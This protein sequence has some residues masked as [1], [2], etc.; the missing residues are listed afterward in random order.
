MRDGNP[1]FQ[2]EDSTNPQGNRFPGSLQQGTRHTLSA[3]NPDATTSDNWLAREDVESP[4]SF[5]QVYSDVLPRDLCAE[6]IGRFENDPRVRP[7]WGK[8][9]DQPKNRTGSMLEIG[10][11]PEWEGLTGHVMAAIEERIHHYAE[12]FLSFKGVLMSDKCYLTPPLME[13]I[14]PDQGFDWHS[15]GSAPGVERRVLANIIYLADVTRG[16]ETQFAYQ[17][18]AVAP[19]AGSLVIFPPFWTHLHRGATPGSEVK[20]NITNFVNLE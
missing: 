17:R 6:I 7:S 3:R 14:V 12:I 1:N 11:L 2:T 9:S 10:Y 13:R 18:S 19:T 20:Y 5:I 4:P 8:D 16:G 15:D